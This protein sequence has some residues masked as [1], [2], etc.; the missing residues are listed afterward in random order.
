[1]IIPTA[2]NRLFVE[3]RTALSK[4]FPP[5]KVDE[6]FAYYESLRKDFRLDHY[7]NCLVNGGKFAEAVLKCLRYLRLGDVVDSLNAGEEIGELG[8]ASSTT[9]LGDSQ[10]LLIPRVLRIVYDHRNKRGGAHNT[11]FDP[12]KMDCTLVLALSS[13]V[14][15][16]L[17]RLY[18]T[19]DP[20]AA[21]VLVSNLL[22]KELIFVEE[23]DGDYLV[24]HPKLP[25]RIQIELLLYKHYPKRCLTKDLARWIHTHSEDNVRV[26]LRNMKEKNLIHENQ[27]GWIL[28]EGGIKE[29]EEEIAKLNNDIV[30]TKKS[31]A[32]KSKGA[33]RG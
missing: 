31:P 23:I 33:K 5:A 3:L 10:R 9:S 11:S 12:T 25:A 2:T 27:D 4:I 15:E 26:S 30:K 29:A 21:Q 19:N 16:E 22:T 17:S 24:S 28:A 14:L 7:D 32:A 20:V 1:M 18:L 8:R 13:W 6:V